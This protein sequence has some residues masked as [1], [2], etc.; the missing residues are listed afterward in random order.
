MYIS[1]L[2]SP[3]QYVQVKLNKNILHASR[4]I[5]MKSN[6]YIYIYINFKKIYLYTWLMRDEKIY[7]VKY[8]EWKNSFCRM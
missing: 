6:R 5:K 3:K 4:I 7:F 2:I 8:E 1:I